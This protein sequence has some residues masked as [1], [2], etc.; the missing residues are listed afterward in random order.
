MHIKLFSTASAQQ[1]HLADTPIIY[2]YEC[3]TSDDVP[4]VSL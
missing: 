4:A 3:D 1:P 2:E